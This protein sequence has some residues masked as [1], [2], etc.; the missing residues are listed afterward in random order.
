MSARNAVEAQ[1]KGH[2]TGA[3]ICTAWTQHGPASV[4]EIGG[5]PELEDGSG[6]IKPKIGLDPGLA[7]STSGGQMIPLAGKG[8][9]AKEAG[10]SARV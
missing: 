6:L 8:P 7:W 4:V 9:S 2:G 1:L 10:S 5:C 3:R